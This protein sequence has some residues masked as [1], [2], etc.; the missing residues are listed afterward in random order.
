MV[1]RDRFAEAVGDTKVG[2]ILDTETTG[3]DPRTDQIIELAMLAFEYDSRSQVCRVVDR[4]QCFADPGR[5]IPPEVTKLTGISDEMVAGHAIDL[6]AVER[7]VASAVIVVAH[8]AGFDRRFAERLHPVFAN[9][10]WA[11]SLAD[12]PWASAGIGSAK[13][14]YLS[15]RFG[16]F[17]EAHR[18]I[19]DCEMLLEILAR[20]LPG[21][22]E[23][24][25]KVLLETARQ[26]T[27]RLWALDSPYDLKDRLKA[28]GYRWGDGADGNPKC[29][30]RDV[31][32][33]D[34][35]AEKAYLEAEIYAAPF[36]PR[37][38]RI[39]ALTRYSDRI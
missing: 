18:A 20:P 24:A 3:L 30:F 26:P 27:W 21:T 17:H 37:C 29:W 14:D 25:L 9:K 34:L 39:T 32:E 22:E 11:C 35:E 2:I 23:P 36:E 31:P 38:V 7:L 1:S 19:A 8:N 4:Y 13:L 28:R 33:A 6:E 15:M 10:H 12:V 16:M 5:P